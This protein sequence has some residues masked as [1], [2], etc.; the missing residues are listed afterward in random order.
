MDTH[1]LPPL[2]LRS[3]NLQTTLASLKPRKL[4]A[5][6]R[7]SRL[8]QNSRTMVLDCGEG[9]RL[10][11]AISEGAGNTKGLVILIHGWEGSID[12]AYILSA[13]AWLFNHGY[14]VF[15][16]NLRDHGRSHHLNREL[17]NS[18]RLAEVVNGIREIHR[19]F[20]HDRNFLS[21]FS[22]GGNFCLRVGL[23]APAAR[24]NLN[25][26]VV[27]C[28]LIDPA[29][30]TR[31]LQEN[32]PVYHRYFVRKWKRSLALKFD[33]FPDLDDREYFLGLNSLRELHNHF[34]PRHTAYRT[35]QD[36][37]RAYHISPEQLAQMAI[38]TRIIA[39]A[40][41]PI[42]ERADIEGLARTDNLSIDLLNY[43]GHCGFLKNYRLHCWVDERLCQIF[44]A[45]SGIKPFP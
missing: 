34:V 44:D 13:G 42:I 17:F 24:L 18:A 6:H 16:L 31:N 40:D 11:G 29:A 1:F 35:T 33:L 39:A 27:V 45:A 8:L 14:N 10:L 3:C 30:T 9:I 36:Y 5:V 32:H 7:A 19:I 25:A 4:L 26:I 2:L 43:G 21:G 37:F 28:P 38:P 12:S 20:P 22:L 23:V 41:D 15:R